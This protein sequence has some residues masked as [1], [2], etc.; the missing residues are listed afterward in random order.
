MKVFTYSDARQKFSS[1][2]ESAQ[3]EGQVL[4]RRKDGRLFSIRPE[5]SSKSP[6]DVQGIKSSVTTRDIIETLREARAEQIAGGDNA[7]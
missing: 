1:V 6:F 2:L 7:R 5:K 4:V 3:L